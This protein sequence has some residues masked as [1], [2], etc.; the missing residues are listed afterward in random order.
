MTALDIVTLPNP[1]LRRKTRPVTEFGADLQ[2]LI[3][4][5]IET[6]RGAPGVGLAAPQVGQPLRL[7]VIETLPKVD[8]DGNEIEESRELFVIANPE[9][10]WRSRDELLGVEGCL[11]IPGYVGEVS[12]A[13]KIRVRAQDRF[14]RKVRLRLSGWTARIFQHEIDHLNGILYIDKLTD[15]ENFWT[16]EEFQAMQEAAEKEEAV[17]EKSVAINQ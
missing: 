3:D 8:E 17:V 16:E 6:M 10:V 13:E 1:V 7:S 11:S 4:D 9:I 14:G 15:K 5:M 12:R 2:K